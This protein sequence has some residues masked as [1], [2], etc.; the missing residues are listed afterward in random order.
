MPK[1]IYYLTTEILPF[2][3]VTS[4]AR[5][6]T[7]LARFSTSY[8]KVENL[9]RNDRPDSQPQNTRLK[10]LASEVKNLASEVENLARNSWLNSQPCPG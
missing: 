3:D 4:L 7:S 9:S 8:I 10:N 2:A 1:K 5:F 6:S